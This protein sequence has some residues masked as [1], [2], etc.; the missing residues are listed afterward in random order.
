M[1]CRKMLLSIFIVFFVSFGVSVFTAGTTYALNHSSNITSDETWSA[2]DNPH[3]VTGPIHVYNNATLTIK[4]GCL[5]K[6]DIN[7]AL[8][9]GY[10]SAATLNATGTSG[11]PITF[12]SNAVTPAPDDWQGIVFFDN[13]VDGSTILDHCTVEYGGNNVYIANINCSSA[14]PAIQN[15]TIHHSS[16]YGIYCDINS[17]P[18]LTNNTIS[19]NGSFPISISCNNLDTNV[20]GNTGSGNTPN[21]IE[22]RDNNI[23]SSH[24]W[25]K[26]DFYFNVTASLHVYNG[27]T[28]TIP[29]GCLVK[30]NAGT[31]LYIGYY[32]AG[33]L[34]ATGTNGNPITFT[35]NAA[36]PAP[37]D[38]QGI[39]FFDNTVDG[40]TILD[41]CTVEYGG[42]NVYIANIY[43]SNASPTIK[44]C[45]IQH[46][47]NYGIYCD[48]NSAP[49]LTNNTI[50]NNGSF[51]ISISCNNLDTNVTGNTG[52]GNTPNAIEVRDNNISSSHTW[53]KQDFYFNVTASL[54]VYNGATLTIPPGC[55]VKFNAGTALYI[56][57]YN[58]GTLN[59]TGTSVSPITFT[60]NA[61]TPAP[62]DW[63]GIVFFDNTVDGSTILDHCTVEYGGNNIYN[64]NIYC[65]NASPTIKNCTI[66]LSGGYGIYC[67]INS[68]PTLTNNTISNNGLFP[69]SESSDRLDSNVTG[70]T[71]SGNT[72]DAI[73]VRAQN[74]V[75]SHTWVP[76]DFY[77][78]VTGTNHIYNGATLTINPG[79]LVKFSAGT[80]LYVGYYNAATLNA[81]G[82]SVS[83]ITFT[84]N[85][86]TPAPGDWQGIVF[87]GNTVSASTI[88][89]YC[90]VEYGGNASYNSNINCNQSY[91]TIRRCIIRNSSGSGISTTGNDSLPSITCSDIVNNKNGVYAESNSHPSISDC[92]IAG[93]KSSGVTNTTSA[94][95]ID[96]KN[97]WWGNSSGPSGAGPG[98]GDAVS[99]YVSYSPWLTSFDSC[100]D[101]IVLSPASATNYIG[102]Q[103]TVT[104]TVT[105]ESD[106]PLEG[107]TVSFNITSG[108]HAGQNGT[109]KTDDDGEVTFTYT[110]TS[111]G[112]DT[113][114]ASFV[115]FHGRT[116][117]TT[118]TKTW[119][120]PATPIPTPTPSPTP[121]PTP[122]PS[123]SPS[124]TPVITP[125][126]SPSPTP[127]PTPEPTPSPSPEPTPSPTPEPSPTG[128]PTA[129]S[130]LSFKATAK[131]NGQVILAWQTGTEMDN[132]GFN[133]YRART[134][135]GDYRK[136][137]STLIPAS[138]NA[139][140]GADYSYT[141][142]PSVKGKYFYKLE[143]V[144]YNGV[145]TMHG[146][147]K[148]KVKKPYRA[149]GKKHK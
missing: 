30:F 112:T 70:N 80:G 108:P 63:Q 134:K 55:L 75:S 137:N 78:N 123:P 81:T 139:S 13:T 17:A 54:H 65:S 148:V 96:A 132:A 120:A 115:D 57:Y 18:T 2:G 111:A 5:V 114:E 113:I 79:S 94:T 76:Q 136:I 1:S 121:E 72:P 67:D 105:D 51:P 27:A 25:V 4:P 130:L 129:I 77:F 9:I 11:S 10:Y 66:R 138:G 140:T 103:H 40:S 59:A 122:S 61:V 45:T 12:T 95:T 110:G 43:C 128:T 36:T 149:K 41:H 19:N 118:A 126:P 89:D 46:S 84:S 141:D 20:T 23:S 15:C 56:G 53:V 73:E 127:S 102:S 68:A 7:A 60:S 107:V 133:I 29:P 50:S 117:S 3:I 71:G 32:S 144:D 104:A 100:L 92:R 143:D 34:N 16:N 101:K 48:I 44:N 69:I 131:G 33:T 37:G 31:A 35:S 6:F 99:S 87:F 119:K 124:P 58:A 91:P 116:I 24:T 21:A 22:V 28:L 47:S 135:D 82:T 26:Q 39:V 64:S 49:T 142:A 52:S 147:D 97:N 106:N 88:L 8:Y 74:I 109:G 38:W 62:D 42:N 90:T 83:P 146:P 93:N 145:S 98:T 14:S 125:T 85:E 86:A